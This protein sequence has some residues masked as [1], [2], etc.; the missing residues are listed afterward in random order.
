MYL[1]AEFRSDPP[2]PAPCP[3]KAAQPPLA[4][5]RGVSLSPGAR[6][7]LAVLVLAGGVAAGVGVYRHATR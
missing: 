4:G 7:A 5:L 6:F 1:T 2:S 3:C